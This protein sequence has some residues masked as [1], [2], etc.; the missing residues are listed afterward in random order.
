MLSFPGITIF[1][2]NPLGVVYL[3]VGPKQH[4][5][6]FVSG[7]VKIEGDS[8]DIL[9]HIVELVGQL[10]AEAKATREI[11]S[12]PPPPTA[13]QAFLQN[14]FT[15]LLRKDMIPESTMEKIS[16]LNLIKQIHIPLREKKSKTAKVKE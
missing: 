14:I 8:G 4:T 13:D 1:S 12:M 6:G 7:Q 2:T 11:N 10:E 9:R 16:L 15:E 3:Q 5:L